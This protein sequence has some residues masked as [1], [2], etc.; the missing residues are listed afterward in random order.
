M[1]KTI[2]AIYRGGMIQPMDKI[3][4]NENE[5]VRITITRDNNIAKEKSTL[6]PENDPI[7]NLIGDVSSGS[8]AGDIDKALYG[9]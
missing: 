6:S 9:E 4:L 5:K 2:K 1:A 8:L 3:E 7:L